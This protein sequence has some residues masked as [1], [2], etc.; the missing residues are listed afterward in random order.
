MDLFHRISGGTPA[1]HLILLLF[2]FPIATNGWKFSKSSKKHN[3]RQCGSSGNQCTCDDR[4]YEVI[5]GNGQDDY[6]PRPYPDEEDTYCFDY[7]VA[8]IADPDSRCTSEP[9]KSIVMG[10]DPQYQGCQDMPCGWYRDMIADTGCTCRSG[11]AKC[12]KT[13]IVNKDQDTGISGVKFEF[14]HPIIDDD[15]DMVVYMCVRGVKEVQTGLI[16]YYGK[17][18]YAYSCDQYEIP[19]FCKGMRLST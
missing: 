13:S 5:Y 2:L 14:T 3:T 6:T 8:R 15:D 19:A 4:A 16:G 1:C 11:H 18:A 12:C 10:V 17:G 9:L 7:T